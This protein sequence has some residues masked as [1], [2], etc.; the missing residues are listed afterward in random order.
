MDLV[1]IENYWLIW[2]NYYYTNKEKFNITYEELIEVWVESYH[3]LL[4]TKTCEKLASI[5]S[6]LR[7]EYWMFLIVKD[8]YRSKALY[9]L[10]TK[11][12]YETKW[13]VYIKKFMNSSWEYRHSSWNTVD[14]GFCKI[15]ESNEIVVRKQFKDQ[16]EYIRSCALWYF[17]DSDTS[18]EKE[19]YKNR[20]FIKEMM[21][22]HWFEWVDHEF[23]HFDLK[24]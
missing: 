11:K 14:V 16:A 21:N 24:E 9:E 10:I 22:S 17:K 23:W 7:K 5:D 6:I 8:A 18:N 2:S 1:R 3:A 20:L 13:E 15:W 19:I 4:N 12:R